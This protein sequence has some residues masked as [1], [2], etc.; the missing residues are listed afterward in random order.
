MSKAMYQVG[1]F[2]LKFAKIEG[3]R[4]AD[5]GGFS[6]KNFKN[7]R[8]MLGIFRQRYEVKEGLLNQYLSKY[9][10]YLA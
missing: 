9:L 7:S 6:K 1:F 10:R 4:T 5:L 8:S 2:P 3:C